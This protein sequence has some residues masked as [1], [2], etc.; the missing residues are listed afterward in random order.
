MVECKGNHSSF[1]LGFQELQQL[2]PPTCPFSH[3]N[4]SF[5]VLTAHPS[6][7]N[8]PLTL[9]SR[10]MMLPFTLSTKEERGYKEIPSTLFFSCHQSKANSFACV[11]LLQFLLQQESFLRKT[12]FQMS[13]GIFLPGALKDFVSDISP[14]FSCPEITFLYNS[15]C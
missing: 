8:K 5:Q 11:F 14:L 9:W 13:S 12:S 6:L 15:V 4:F 3:F 2:L 1:S 10:K 7:P